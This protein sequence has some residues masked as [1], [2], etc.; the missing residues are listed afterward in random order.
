[1]LMISWMLETLPEEQQ[2]GLLAA[3]ICITKWHQKLHTS[4]VNYTDVLV[5]VSTSLHLL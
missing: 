5:P 2:G 3:A 1:M 4:P